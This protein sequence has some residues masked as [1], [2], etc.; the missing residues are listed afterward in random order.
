MNEQEL[1]HLKQRKIR[2]YL[3]SKDVQELIRQNIQR[4]RS[5]I[6]VTI[7]RAV[8]LFNFTENQLRDWED[9]GLIKPQRSKDVTGQRQYSLTELD[10]LA[11]IRV[12]ID[13]KFAP[14][15]IPEDL[16]DHL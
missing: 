9:R 13:A 12:L 3:E 14:G 16:I 5:E 2:Q 7:G 15:D 6:A 10:K 8:R 11:I 4:G 1:Q